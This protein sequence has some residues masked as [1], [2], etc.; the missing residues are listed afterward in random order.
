LKMTGVCCTC[1]E[2]FVGLQKSHRLPMHYSVGGEKPILLEKK[3][4]ESQRICG[5]CQ[6]INQELLKH[7]GIWGIP[8]AEL[9][10]LPTFSIEVAMAM[11]K[12]SG[13]PS[14]LDS[15]EQDN[16]TGEE[17]NIET[18]EKLNAS[19]PENILENHIPQTNSCSSEISAT[20]TTTT[21][22]EQ[23]EHD[24]QKEKNSSQSSTNDEEVS[25]DEKEMDVDKNQQ[26]NY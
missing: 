20:T 10:E 14:K 6:L 2:P 4:V 3:I 21:T 26:K 22:T 19:Q 16:V 17:D 11:R 9:G 13:K 24:I 12:Q 18:P 23:E 1:G 7:N 25:D 5:R 8:I 15:K